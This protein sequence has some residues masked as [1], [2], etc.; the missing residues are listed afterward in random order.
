MNFSV[1][2]PAMFQRLLSDLSAARL[3]LCVAAF[4]AVLFALGYVDA[5][6]WSQVT[7]LNETGWTIANWHTSHDDLPGHLREAKE[8]Q[9]PAHRLRYF[10]IF[11]L[12]WFSDLTQISVHVLYSACVPFMAGLVVWSAERVI[13]HQGQSGTVGWL[14]FVALLR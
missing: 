9:H 11:P 5:R 1:S 2:I 6:L 4:Y 10:L 14:G 3:A 8:R 12:F 13:L 7:D